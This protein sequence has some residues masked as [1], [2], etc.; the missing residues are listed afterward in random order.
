MIIAEQ[1]LMRV[2]WLDLEAIPSRYHKVWIFYGAKLS[3]R[4]L[5]LA[6]FE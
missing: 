2:Y 3:G 1:H 5:D 6:G 4:W